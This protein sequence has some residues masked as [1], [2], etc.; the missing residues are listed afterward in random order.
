[1]KNRHLTYERI[2]L[3][4]VILTAVWLAD[5]TSAIAQV[6]I[7]NPSSSTV[8]EHGETLTIA[9]NIPSGT[10]T[11]T[12]ELY[13]GYSYKRT[14]VSGYSN[15]HQYNWNV[16][17]TIAGDYRIRV[18][19]SNDGDA[20]SN[21][22]TV[23]YSLKVTGGSNAT[24]TAGQ[25]MTIRWSTTLN[26]GHLNLD[27]R[28]AAGGWT[29]YSSGVALSATPYKWTTPSGNDYVSNTQVRLQSTS[30]AEVVAYV[31]NISLT[32]TLSLTSPGSGINLAVGDNLAVRWTSNY[33]GAPGQKVKIELYKGGTLKQT[34][35]NSAPNNGSFDWTVPA[36]I[37]PGNDY[38]V[39][40]SDVSGSPSVISESFIL[41]SASANE[42]VRR[43]SYQSYDQW[44]NVR[45]TLDARR[46]PTA[47]K[48]GHNG[49][50]LLVDRR[51]LR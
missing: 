10:G 39:R 24:V 36:T 6:I 14:L 48:W 3:T 44:G 33:T 22:F 20:M 51:K 8:V 16:G 29:R 17:N 43:I 50:M 34:M 42:P 28:N 25:P 15:L 21:M 26:S 38:Q 27:Y 4:L 5:V 40:L 47:Y 37:G 18:I 45:Q 1:M 46:V 32:K 9:Y 2:L 35:A 49:T 7:F 13:E 41:K 23:T 30:H 19:S 11:V 31:N 12:I